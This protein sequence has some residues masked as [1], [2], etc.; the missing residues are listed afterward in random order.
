MSA[1]SLEQQIADYLSNGGLFNPELADHYVV[2][3]LLINCRSALGARG[4][5]DAWREFVETVAKQRPEKPDY[6]SA[7][8]QCEH[9]IS[10]AQDLLAA[11]PVHAA[12][13]AD[14]KPVTTPPSESGLYLVRIGDQTHIAEFN[15]RTATTKWWNAYGSPSR[16][17]QEPTYW[18]PLPDAPK[19]HV[20]VQDAAP[21]PT[22]E[23]QG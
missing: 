8:G 4:A 15:G 1:I 11:G 21:Q 7:C 16:L 23:Q 3:D 6:W 12:L 20:P 5:P 13:V 10:D 2:R 17:A 9:N 19:S 22:K 14:W 18:M